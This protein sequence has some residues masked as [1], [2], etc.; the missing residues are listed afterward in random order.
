MLRV[1]L[2]MAFLLGTMLVAAAVGLPSSGQPVLAQPPANCDWTGV[3]LPFEGEWRLAQNGTSVSGSYLDGKGIVSGTIDGAVL[4]GEWKEAPTYS[5]PFEAGH[6]IVTMTSN[7]GGFVGTW[8][9]GDAECCND[10]SAIRDE[11]APQALAVQVER[12]TLVVDG[13]TIPTGNTYFPPACSPTGLSAT[14]DCATTFL[15][16]SET[17]IKFS[18]FVNR[19]LRVLLVLE[20]VDLSVEDYDLLI[21]VVAIK[22]REKCGLTAVR[23]E[24]WSLDLAVR[25][26]S[27]RVDSVIEGQMLSVAAGPATSMLD[28]PGSFQAG[29]DSATGKAVFHT[30][31]SPLDMLPQTGAVFTLPPFSR[32]EVTLA[33]PGPVTPLPHTYLPM[34]QR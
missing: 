1:L 6:F 28:Q 8:G 22:L 11:N 19:L 15:L 32:V 23:Q 24:G 30:Y 3:W 31:S 17:A 14:D 27:A 10:L 2:L 25:E 26:G 12:G 4:R 34:M 20:N 13:Q 16:G 33:G 29:Y 7:C 5:P 18:C 21:D 9:L